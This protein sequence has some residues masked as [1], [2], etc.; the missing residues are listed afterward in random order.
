M[1]IKSDYWAVCDRC[2]D[3]IPLPD[4]VPGTSVMPRTPGEAVIVARKN[5]QWHGTVKFL[6]CVACQAKTNAN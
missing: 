4:N 3:M 2:G 5:Y 6:V 1:G